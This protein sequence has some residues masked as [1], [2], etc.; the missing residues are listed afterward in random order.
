VP[1]LPLGDRY[2][3]LHRPMETPG[4]AGSQQFQALARYLRA[5]LALRIRRHRKQLVWKRPIDANLGFELGLRPW[6]PS[7]PELADGRGECRVWMMYA[8]EAYDLACAGSMGYARPKERS[9]ADT[10]DRVCLFPGGNG[11]LRTKELWHLSCSSNVHLFMG[12]SISGSSWEPQAAFSRYSKA[13][14]IFVG[15][16][17]LPMGHHSKRVGAPRV[18]AR[19][20][21]SRN[22]RWITT[23]S[24]SRNLSCVNLWDDLVTLDYLLD[25]V[26]DNAV[27]QPYRALCEL[28]R[29]W[30]SALAPF[31]KQGVEKARFFI[32]V[33]S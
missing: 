21:S 26:S 17:W 23:L 9:L 7:H 12:A 4:N 13:S 11:V 14:W 24:W 27:C 30:R 8:E 10:N 16:F 19:D 1:A 2:I 18:T 20:I 28:G 25:A 6:L 15:C 22:L 32:L 3:G 5:C 29:I 33:G 31:S